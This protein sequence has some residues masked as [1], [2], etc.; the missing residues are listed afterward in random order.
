[1]E[2]QDKK[3]RLAAECEKLDQDIERQLAEEVLA[4]ESDW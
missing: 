1:M 2:N 4:G 3:A